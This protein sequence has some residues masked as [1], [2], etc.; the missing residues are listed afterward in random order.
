MV[1]LCGG[2][3]FVAVVVY[4]K[5]VNIVRRKRRVLS[6][7]RTTWHLNEKAFVHEKDIPE[8]WGLDTPTISL[9]WCHWF[10]GAQLIK[11]Q[12]CSTAS[13]SFTQ[14][15]SN[16]GMPEFYHGRF[17]V[18]EHLIRDGWVGPEGQLR[19][20]FRYT[21][22]GDVERGHHFIAKDAKTGAEPHFPRY[23]GFLNHG[24]TCY[25]NSALQG[26]FHIGIF[27][28]ILYSFGSGRRTRELDSHMKDMLAHWK[29][30]GLNEALL[31][32]GDRDKV[33]GFCGKYG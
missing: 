13:G 20:R 1:K 19:L 14:S 24:A 10:G 26:F 25:L 16:W 27:R 15:F 7:S 2:R 21:S 33:G 29:K 30:H 28:K 32:I 8:G 5:N 18:K 12:H 9:A 6:Y 22:K 4:Y 23:S 17:L 3:T 31:A 11:L